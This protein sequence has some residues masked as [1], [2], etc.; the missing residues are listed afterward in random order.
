MHAWSG[1][2]PD[3]EG[4]ISG[5]SR[6]QLPPFIVPLFSSWSFGQ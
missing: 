4:E 2:S 5:L 1:R 6:A 3:Q